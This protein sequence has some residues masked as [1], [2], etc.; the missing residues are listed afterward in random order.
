[1]GLENNNNKISILSSHLHVCIEKQVMTFVCSPSGE[2]CK[3]E[4]KE[5]PQGAPP[6]VQTIKKTHPPNKVTS[7]SWVLS[8]CDCVCVYLFVCVCVC[9]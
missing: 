6:P 8:F 9:V 4:V 3:V 7:R 2:P 1:M 5:P